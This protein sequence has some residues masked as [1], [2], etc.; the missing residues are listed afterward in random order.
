M[1][2]SECVVEGYILSKDSASGR[3]EVETSESVLL[4]SVVGLEVLEHDEHPP[5]E[6]VHLFFF[7]LALLC[8]VLGHLLL[9]LL[10]Q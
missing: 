2:S 10:L 3:S 1:Q 4:G 9:L 8:H 7:L 5:L 6:L